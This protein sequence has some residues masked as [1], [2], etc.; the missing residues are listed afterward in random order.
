MSKI[1]YEDIN[2]VFLYKT[3]LRYSIPKCYC[4]LGILSELNGSLLTVYLKEHKYWM[5]RESIN[6]THSKV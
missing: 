3:R 6:S 5:E 4:V 1:I 2:A